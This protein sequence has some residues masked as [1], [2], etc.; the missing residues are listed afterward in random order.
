MHKHTQIYKDRLTINKMMIATN[1][2]TINRI[3]FFNHNNNSNWDIKRVT[4]NY[5]DCGVSWTRL[6]FQHEPDMN[7]LFY[8]IYLFI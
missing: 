4:I 5:S 7:C 2:M 8:F 3:S 6:E 1:K